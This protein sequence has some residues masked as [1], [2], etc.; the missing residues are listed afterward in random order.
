MMNELT[1]KDLLDMI[2][3]GKEAA[4]WA[5]AVRMNIANAK[6]LGMPA[7]VLGLELIAMDEG[8]PNNYLLVGGK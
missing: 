4:P 5:D 7:E 1:T 6:K 8:F 2:K 3:A